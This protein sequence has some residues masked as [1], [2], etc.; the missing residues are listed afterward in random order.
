MALAHNVSFLTYL[1]L[2]VC[3]IFTDIVGF[4][5]I[6]MDIQPKDVMDM[7]Q[8]LFFRFDEL[9]DVHGVLKLE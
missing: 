3:I 7:L 4:S 1:P 6:A 8:D 5:R 2:S 9:C